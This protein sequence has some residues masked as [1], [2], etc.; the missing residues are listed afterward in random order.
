M[1][2]QTDFDIASFHLWDIL[3]TLGAV[4]SGG[5]PIFPPTDGKARG[6]DALDVFEACVEL[7]AGHLARRE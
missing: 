7:A 4:R 1:S 6:L 5:I 3:M 2:A